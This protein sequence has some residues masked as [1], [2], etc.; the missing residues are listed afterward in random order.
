[1]YTDVKLEKRMSDHVL[2][3]GN[4][5]TLTLAHVE[6]AK[7]SADFLK[8]KLSKRATTIESEIHK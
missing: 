7:Q 3:N 5:E 4:T 1:M 8:Q 2:V 6:C